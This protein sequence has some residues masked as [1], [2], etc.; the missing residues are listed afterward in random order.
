MEDHIINE[1]LTNGSINT[2]GSVPV[3]HPINNEEN[4]DEIIPETATCRI[5]RGDATPDNPLF[6][7][8]RCKGSIKYLHEPCLLEWINARHI[9]I[10]KL[11][12][13][14][15]C[16]IC[17]YPFQFK[18]TYDEDMPEKIPLSLVIV[19]SFS[20]VLKTFHYHFTLLAFI[21]MIGLGFPLVWN[22]FGKLYT[23]IMDGKMPYEGNF[24]K[25]I[26]FGY[27]ENVPDDYTYTSVL[28]A[29]LY[30]HIFSL[31]QII[32]TVILHLAIYFQYDMIVRE[33]IF[34]KMIFHK[35]GPNLSIDALKARLRERFPMI[36]DDTL[37]HVARIVSQREIRENEA[38]NLQNMEL[39]DNVDVIAEEQE[40][41]VEENTDD[42]S[43]ADFVP[44][45]NDTQSDS[46][47]SVD[48]RVIDED[49]LMRQE[50]ERGVEGDNFQ[51]E[52][53]IDNMVNLQAQRQFD[54]I[55]DRH[56]N[57]RAHNIPVLQPE[58]QEPVVPQEDPVINPFEN[59]DFGLADNENEEGR[60]LGPLWINLQIKSS[61]IF[62]YFGLCVG[63][64]CFY[65]LVAYGIPTTVG[66]IL[67]RIYNVIL[68]LAYNSIW[69]L[70]HYC[71]FNRGYRLILNNVP[72]LTYSVDF[73]SKRLV[74]PA[75]NFLST[76][77]LTT[78]KNSTYMRAI[79][80]VVTFMTTVVI[81][82]VSSEILG[83]GYS[84]YN[85]MNDKNRRFAFQLLFALRC[86]FKVF[87]IF[88]I[89]LAGF[90]ILAGAML[91]FSLACPILGKATD[92]LFFPSTC[93]FNFQI[94]LEY[95][96]IGTLYMYWFAKYIG[97]IRKDI[98][99]PGVL[100]FIRSPEDPNT[101]ILQDSL[102][103]PMRSQLS[104]LFLSMFIYAVFIILGFG[105][106]TKV[107][108]PIILKSQIL[109][110]PDDFLDGYVFNKITLIIIFYFTKK[111]IEA[112]PNVNILVKNYW[113]KIFEVSSRKLRLSSFILGTDY[114]SERGHIVYRNIFY[115]LF[116][117]KKAQWSNADLY[118]SPKTPSVALKLFKEDQS[119]HA[120]FVP[121]GLLMR[122]PSSDIV[123]RNYVQT[124]FVSVTK[125]DKL[126]K[127]LDLKRLKER[128]LKNAGE[129][130]YLEQQN[131]DFDEYF[132]CYVPPNFTARYTGL[133][134]LMWFF[135]SVL[136]ISTAIVSQYLFNSLTLILFLLPSKLLGFDSSYTSLLKIVLVSYKQ[137]NVHYVCLG[138]IIMSF[139]LDYYK[140]H[141]L[142]KY[143]FEHRTAEENA[144]ELQENQDNAAERDF[145]IRPELEELIVDNFISKYVIGPQLLCAYGVIEYLL[146]GFGYS[147]VIHICI[148]YIEFLVTGEPMVVDADRIQKAIH[149]KL[150]IFIVFC[151]FR[152]IIIRSTAIGNGIRTNGNRGFIVSCREQWNAIVK[153]QLKFV[154]RCYIIFFSIILFTSI[155]EYTLD[156]DHYSS[157]MNALKFII[158]G[159]LRSMNSNVPWTFPQHLTFILTIAF[160]FSHGA[161]ELYGSINKWFKLFTQN[162][163]DEVYANGRSLENYG[164]DTVQ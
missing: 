9:D 6:H 158:L 161:F 5:C 123:S 1:N 95:W 106:N 160:I 164:T 120:Y 99:R 54:D 86:T 66:Y 129:F 47:L 136:I 138:A 76:Y 68:Q 124:M 22:F 55:L 23:F 155:F 41:Q 93:F 153:P 13:S 100:F 163:K 81:I 141:H 58:D 157:F 104:R 85:S 121:D 62:L 91:D 94:L 116:S 84:R 63:F 24:M 14:V 3:A 34:N 36:D 65:M 103:H 139:I 69:Y 134:V 109:K 119:I 51:L 151:F 126:L 114:A 70:I 96:L 156:T 101:K 80:S 42:E 154:V 16:D 137:A 26:I 111:I 107:L 98:I 48:D 20:D 125:S 148:A 83:K 142:S 97:M 33:D 8:C 122:V 44:S 40:E 72:G 113:S 128:N 140:K 115:K 35:I 27:E 159:R 108:F 67:I 147:I 152:P 61:N 90:P 162:V 82:C 46:D 144:N 135:A 45:D 37:E 31:W 87:V 133:L 88:F 60:Q 78:S 53:P 143:F 145:G 131:T 15:E 117:S 74:L 28:T 75:F 38:R 77:Y 29:L 39:D 132:I 30:N 7:P 110:T 150:Y 112:N 49:E 130:G 89:E 79:P 118:T 64:V 73:I 11:G 4:K 57:L 149:S 52:H 92:W 19:N 17:H 21:I 2:P 127:P 43:D 32:F 12:T 146:L 71:K 25:S 50:V 18:T 56:R 59:G 102:I 10:N 105:L